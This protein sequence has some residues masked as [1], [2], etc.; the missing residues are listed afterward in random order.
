MSPNPLPSSLS[1][2]AAPP[3]HLIVVCC[4]GIW[5][6]GPSAGHDEAEWLLAPF[7]AGETPTFV[8][9]IEEGV[10]AHAADRA[11]SV[12]V[13][14]G[15]ATRPET[16]LSEAQSYANVAAQNRYFG[17][18]ILP[19]SESESSP[20]R[21]LLEERALDSFSNVLFSLTLFRARVGAWPAAL[22]V[23]GHAFKRP[24][25]EAHVAAV[26]FPAARTRHVGVD[27]PAIGR[28]LVA[29]AAAAAAV[30][31][32]ATAGRDAG[33]GA[34]GED[35]EGE[36][37]KG[38][39]PRHHP[40]VRGIRNAEREWRDD[41]HGRGES[42]AGKRR[43]RNVWAAWQGVFERDV[44]DRGGLETVGEGEEERLVDE[45]RRPWL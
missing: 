34:E 15:A 37:E 41:P 40:V 17:H 16:Q 23:V 14:S 38:E 9:H 28:V 8:R 11:D 26:G 45:A 18:L 5:L 6:G 27:P 7:Q 32:A 42:L 3:T 1:A 10:R 4:H 31:T 13:F 21:I 36:D 24:R 2:A 29:A 43:G 20:A 19:G 44:T 12:L 35:G 33:G 30:A 25:M 22:T 39:D